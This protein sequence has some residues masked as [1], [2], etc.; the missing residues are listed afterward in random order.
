M[1]QT[2][3]LAVV[4]QINLVNFMI[5]ARRRRSRKLN[6]NPVLGLRL[7]K[8]RFLA[9]LCT[10]ISREDKSRCMQGCSSKGDY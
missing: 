2:R 8:R 7:S 9:P 6:S 1:S 4:V 5:Y 10:E 3:K